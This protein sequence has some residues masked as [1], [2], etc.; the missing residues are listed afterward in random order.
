MPR[1][2]YRQA[3]AFYDRCGRW[4]DLQ[5]SLEDPAFDDLLAHAAL[6][7]AGRVVEFGCGTG[8][9]A[10]RLFTDGLSPR[11]SYVGFDLSPTM[12]RLSRTRLASFG[13]RAQ[14]LPVSGPPRLPLKDG[15]CDRFLCTYV[16]DLLS[17]ADADAL[18]RQA[19]RLL[20][21]GGRLCI[22]VMA[23]HSSLA[24]RAFRTVWTSLH[25]LSPLFVGG[26]QPAD[27]RV[28]LG[29]GWELRHCRLVCRFAVCSQVLVA[30]RR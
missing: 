10:Q 5:R 15:C 17:P 2:S 30:V 8:R 25:R 21:P 28:W 6:P 16:L 1:I 27:A 12:L 26:T 11:A 9:L 7:S 20:A 23:S 22:A 24:N 29:V 18:V 3:R 14:V 19:Y 13:P 4:L